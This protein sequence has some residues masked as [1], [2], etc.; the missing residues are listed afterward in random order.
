MSLSYR[1][2]LPLSTGW[3]LS[4]ILMA[5][6]N[7]EPSGLKLRDILYFIYSK[8]T[9]ER[10]FDPTLADMHLEWHEAMIHNRTWLA[11]WVQIRGYVTIC[12]TVCVHTVATL[13]NIF[14]LV[15]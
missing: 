4:V 15:K 6:S 2:F 8:K 9:A 1:S 14:K 12:I 3:S 13:G 11:R 10:I 5:S 7:V